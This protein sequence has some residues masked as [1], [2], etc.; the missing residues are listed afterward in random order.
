MYLY[1]VHIHTSAIWL[2]L[3]V[4]DTAVEFLL[5]VYLCIY[6]TYVHMQWLFLCS[7]FFSELKQRHF[8][9]F[10]IVPS[11]AVTQPIFVSSFLPT[12]NGGS[13]LLSYRGLLDQSYISY[14]RALI[15]NSSLYYYR[16]PCSVVCL[17]QA[18]GRLL[19]YEVDY[20]FLARE[21]GK[22]EHAVKLKQVLA[23][24]QL[25]P[26]SGEVGVRGCGGGGCDGGCGVG[27]G[28]GGVGTAA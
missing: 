19:L 9:F 27:G 8:F 23:K 16:H 21:G 11:A 7:I 25:G 20:A 15:C 22:H 24:E 3:H 13:L 4:A 14:I 2:F 18:R 1:A 10:F 6:S 26:V 17:V 5:V 12:G 28:L